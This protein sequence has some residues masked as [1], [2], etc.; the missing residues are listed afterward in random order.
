[1]FKMKQTHG[2]ILVPSRPAEIKLRQDAGQMEIKDDPSH[3]SRVCSISLAAAADWVASVSEGLGA[4]GVGGCRVICK[5]HSI[6]DVGPDN[7]PQKLISMHNPRRK[8]KA[9]Q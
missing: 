2:G 5:C 3:S 4:E 7:A 6:S 9:R 1:M 8:H